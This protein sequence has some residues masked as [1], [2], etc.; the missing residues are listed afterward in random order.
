MQLPA[1]HHAHA[2]LPG[3]TP[4]AAQTRAATATSVL[5][6]MLLYTPQARD[7]AGGVAN[8][9]ATAQAAVDNMNTA[10]S[11][12]NVAAQLN[13]VL[14][15]LANHDDAGNLSTDLTWV[16]GDATVA[17]LRAQVGADLVG[18]LVEDGAGFC[19]LGYVM[20]DVGAAFAP[21]AFQVTARTC[22]VGNLSYAHEHGHNLG[23]EHDPANGPAS[24]DASYPWSFGHFVNGSF[25]T[26]MS[27]SIPCAQG[28][29]RVAHFSNPAIN[30]NAQPTGIT[31]QRDNA[32]TLREGDSGVGTTA[33]AAA[34]LASTVIFSDDF[35]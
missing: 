3:I 8:I 28:C 35:E 31:D 29:T 11:N 16:S 14:T 1:D 20:R 23:L 34:F 22:A 7:A 21:N 24:G 6:V 10:F 12:S 5:D 4:L 19:G 2:P 26:V 25:R 9:E 13:L 18:L 33:V 32:R 27:Y 30:Y 15:A 17:A